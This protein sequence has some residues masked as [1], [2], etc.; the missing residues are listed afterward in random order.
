MLRSANKGNLEQK[1][2]PRFFLNQ[3]KII[4]ILM[5]TKIRKRL[6]T[7]LIKGQILNNVL[8][9]LIMITCII[10]YLNNGFIATFLLEIH[11]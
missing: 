9:I 5:P 11:K 6:K 2:C 8:G 4:V 1:K 3:Y 10:K 7:K